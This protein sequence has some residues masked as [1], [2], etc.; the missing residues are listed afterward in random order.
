MA[1]RP[2]PSEVSVCIP[3]YNG[4]PHLDAAIRSARSQV[5]P[6]GEILIVD[7]CSTDES[8]SVARRHAA[9]DPRIA[10]VRNPENLG[11]VGNWNQCVAKARFPWIKFLFQDDLLEPACLQ[12]LCTGMQQVDARMGFVG[13]R[14]LAEPGSASLRRVAASIE[15]R[16]IAQTLPAPKEL[17]AELVAQIAL[18]H[19]PINI[20]GEPTSVLFHRDLFDAHGPFDP[21]FR[22][23]CDW[24]Y[25]IRAGSNEGAWFDPAVLATFRVHSGAASA[26][27][28]GTYGASL[29]QA[30]AARLSAKFLHDPAF[31]ALR[32]LTGRRGVEVF[33]AQ[34]GRTVTRLRRWSS[35]DVTARRALDALA[36]DFGPLPNLSST[37]RLT[38]RAYDL[39]PTRLRNL[40]RDI[41]G[42]GILDRVVSAEEPR[43]S[44]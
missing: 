5:A 28:S 11:L 23:L 14:A 25:W 38:L 21:A 4:L 20:L 39:V 1:D 13:R 12:R 33:G 15:R 24:E 32:D 29:A 7:D 17:S 16:N 40:A 41:R 36:S 10:V 30:E 22:Q 27:N 37:E 8:E 43:S 6:P 19:G 31:E 2:S 35:Q 18:R 3:V 44:G 9:E 42:Q 34:Y 26:T